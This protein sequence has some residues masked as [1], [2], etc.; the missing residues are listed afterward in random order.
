MFIHEPA[1][2]TETD[3]HGPGKGNIK[4]ELHRSRV[5]R[6]KLVSI[7]F[8][9]SAGNFDTARHYYNGRGYF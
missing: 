6:R 8:E 3:E 5:N 2:D 7:L 9:T 1:A 4:T